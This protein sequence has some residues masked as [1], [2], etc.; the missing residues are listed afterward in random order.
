M[1]KNGEVAFWF[2]PLRL[3]SAALLGCPLDQVADTVIEARSGMAGGVMLCYLYVCP[4][5]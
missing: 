2:Q 5:G 1:A 3:S 4:Y